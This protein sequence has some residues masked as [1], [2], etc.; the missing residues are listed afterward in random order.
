MATVN[1]YQCNNASAPSDQGLSRVS[2]M[3]ING[4]VP[5]PIFLWILDRCSLPHDSS[6]NFCSKSLSYSNSI[7]LLLQT[8]VFE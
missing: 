2:E 3:V 4:S 8:T 7:I 6:V 5:P 1:V